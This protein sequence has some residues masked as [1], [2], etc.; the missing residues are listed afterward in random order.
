M[1]RLV[2]VRALL[3]ASLVAGCQFTAQAQNGFRDRIRLYSE[4]KAVPA[5]VE[6]VSKNEIVVSIPTGPKT[7]PASDVESIVYGGAEGVQKAQVDMANG[8]YKEAAEQLDQLD[9]GS[10]DRDVVREELAYLKALCPAK[11]ALSGQADSEDSGETKDPA[12]AATQA[13]VE[14]ID[15]LKKHPTNYHYYE[16]NEIVGDL[17][18][19]IGRYDK[20]EDYYKKLTE[21]PSPEVKARANLLR[22]RAMQ[23]EGKYDGALAAY[24]AL[25]KADLK[26]KL[27]EQEMLEARIGRTYSL[28]G[29]GKVAEAIKILQEIIA[30][31]E[32][33]ETELLARAYDALGNCY[34]KQKDSKQALWAYLR[35]D[36]L[37]RT[38]P[39]AHAE[40]LYNLAVLWAEAKHNDRA[41]EAREYLLQHYPFSRWNKQIR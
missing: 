39:D 28:A 36:M 7:I 38:V 35:V 25:L 3:A 11:I 12:A 26:G 18:M 19:S 33:D 20:A 9:P 15:F 29:S 2:F 16:A 30:K 14:M 37:Y 4:S 22:G 17:A 10:F 41:R 13:I 6:S 40:A 34:R 24:D 31:A 8:K 27:G 5:T 1:I 23:V 32:D 21:S